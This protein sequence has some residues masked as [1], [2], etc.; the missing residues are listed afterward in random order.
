MTLLVDDLWMYYDRWGMVVVPWS[1][2]V[3][4]P[5][6]VGP[7]E[8]LTV[9][10]RLTYPCPQ[11]FD[12]VEKVYTWPTDPFAT[13]TVPPPFA[14]ASGEDATRAINI[15]RGGDSDTVNWSVMSPSEEGYWMTDIQV[16]VGATVT[17]YAISYGWYTDLAGGV[18]AG[19]VGCDA[20]PPVIGSFSVAG[21]EGVVSDPTVSIAFVTSDAHSSVEQVSLSIDGGLTWRPLEGASGGADVLLDRGDGAYDIRLMV[22]DAAGNSVIASRTLLLDSTAPEIVLFQLAG[23]EEVLTTPTIQVA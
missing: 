23:G 1:V 15:T 2:E 22:V 21:G 8:P 20:A 18:G 6:C 14:L 13:I 19:T 10:A 16:M 4:V 11:P 3:T 17:D 12:Q 9:T 5:E 7:G